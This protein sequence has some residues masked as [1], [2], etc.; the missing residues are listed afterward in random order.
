MG[1][2]VVNATKK[3]LAVRYEINPYYYTLFYK[4]HTAGYTVVRPLF[5]E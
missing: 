1:Q 4:A 3:S 5:H 2:P